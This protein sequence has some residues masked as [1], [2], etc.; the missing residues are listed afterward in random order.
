MLTRGLSPCA[1]L[2]C[3]DLD[4]MKSFSVV[5]VR[6]KSLM[7]GCGIFYEKMNHH[8]TVCGMFSF[9]EIILYIKFCVFDKIGYFCSEH[10][11]SNSKT[12]IL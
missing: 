1:L 6:L 4:F 8:G 2:Q 3:L 11:F 9:C 5:R 12:G 10:N 7:K